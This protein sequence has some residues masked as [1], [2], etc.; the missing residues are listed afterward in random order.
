MT[1]AD[2]TRGTIEE[3]MG[4]FRFRLRLKGSAAGIDLIPE[5]VSWHGLPLPLWFLP[6][7]DATERASADGR[8]L[9]DVR[10]ALQPFGRLVH[11]RGWLRAVAR[12]IPN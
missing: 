4:P 1:N 11:Y 6:A 7:I 10:I 5:G 9:F 3:H 12:N 8:H 2:G